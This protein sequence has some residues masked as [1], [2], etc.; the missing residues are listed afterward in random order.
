MKQFIKVLPAFLLVLLVFTACKKKSK[1]ETAPPD[2]INTSLASLGTSA[3]NSLTESAVICTGVVN[4]EGAS[5]VTGFGFCWDKHPNPTTVNA[6]TT[7]GKGSG[8][9][10]VS[11]LGLDPNTTYHARAYA[12]NATGTAYSNDITFK[13]LPAWEPVDFFKNISSLVT[14]G[15]TILALTSEGLFKSTDEGAQW[16]NIGSTFFNYNVNCVT[17]SGTT[18]FVG[19]DGGGV[20]RSIDG[21]NTWLAVNSG[22][23][24]LSIIQIAANGS[25][26][27]SS[28]YNNIVKRSLDN[29]KTWVNVTSG[30][31]GGIGFSSVTFKNTIIYG[32]ASYYG[33]Y[34]SPDNG[35]NW[36]KVITGSPSFSYVYRVVASGANILVSTENGV[37]LS[38]DDAGTWGKIS[39]MS[40][41]QQVNFATKDNDV[42][43]AGN[44]DVYVSH[45]NGL[46]FTT[47]NKGL[48]S[49][50]FVAVG[51]TENNAFVGGY[52]VLYKYPFKQ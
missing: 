12:T 27:L 32:G 35:N 46:T 34:S 3:F 28:S 16:T 2:D 39:S 37:F 47:F 25:V 50:N 49:A 13:T 26:V 4:S 33:L 52:Q 41:T 6:H 11:A 48:P 8:T 1:T 14:S 36:T 24:D 51:V 15:S 19:T 42:Y 23:T 7:I 31:Q 9:F 20:F 43:I 38:S 44:S 40:T 29:G 5:A 30:L 21:G 17:T 22:L 45:D 10:T 18:F